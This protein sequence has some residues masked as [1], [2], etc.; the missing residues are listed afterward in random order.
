VSKSS[1]KVEGDLFELYISKIIYES[2]ND[3]TAILIDPDLLRKRGLGQ[4]DCCYLKNGR[5]Y[6]IECKTGMGLISRGQIRRLTKTSLFLSMIFDKPSSIVKFRA[7]AKTD[8]GHYSFNISNIKEL[9]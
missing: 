6:N 7:F 1:Y 2:N 4:V 3:I 8:S 5:I 9:N